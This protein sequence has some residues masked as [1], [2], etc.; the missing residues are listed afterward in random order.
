MCSS[1]QGILLEDP[2]LAL[3]KLMTAAPQGHVPAFET[4]SRCIYSTDL[5]V[6]SI[7]IYH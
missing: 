2:S 6:A 7:R 5:H 1:V 3:R 4:A